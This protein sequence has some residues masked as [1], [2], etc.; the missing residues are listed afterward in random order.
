MDN[1]FEKR[2]QSLRQLILL[3]NFS[4]Y[5][6]AWP[7]LLN[8]RRKA[9]ALFLPF[10]R[11]WIWIKSVCSN[12]SYKHPPTLHTLSRRHKY[13]CIPIWIKMT[14]NRLEG[15]TFLIGINSEVGAI[16]QHPHI[17]KR[18]TL[19][20]GIQFGVFG[21]SYAHCWRDCGI[22]TR[23]SHSTCCFSTAVLRPYVH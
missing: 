12:G 22:A 3:R 6:S 20:R 18:R 8:R 14:I 2:T 1:D 15:N 9:P 7:T 23:V 4:R 16:L 21:H 11:I 5:Q 10:S 19:W 17:P 13:T